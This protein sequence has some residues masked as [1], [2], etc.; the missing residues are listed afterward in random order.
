MG[1][2]AL[3]LTTLLLRLYSDQEIFLAWSYI[4]TYVTLFFSFALLGAE[5]LIIRY[6]EITH[7]GVIQI[8]KSTITF[9]ILGGITFLFVAIT[10]INGYLFDYTF[11]P[12]SLIPLL[13]ATMGILILYQ[14]N[15]LTGMLAIGQLVMNMWRIILC[16]VIGLAVFFNISVKIEL[17]LTVIMIINL[18]IGYS[19][20]PQINQLQIKKSYQSEGEIFVAFAISLLIMTILGIF[21]RLILDHSL[22]Y[23]GISFEDYFYLMTLVVFPFN[24]LGSYIGYVAAR[25]F[26]EKLT[27]YHFLTLTLQTIIGTF[28]AAIIWINLLEYFTTW[29]DLPSVSKFSWALI[30]ILIVIKTAYALL[31]AATAVKA[32]AK[33]LFLANGVTTMILILIGTFCY[34]YATSIEEV[35]MAFTLAWLSRYFLYIITLRNQWEA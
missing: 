26:R 24:L 19:I 34:Y 7:Q 3:F 6:A 35:I 1:A 25:H 21:D 10:V 9:L 23:S 13:L 29:L 32:K 2:C 14:I 22:N 16:L 31:S 30:A 17:I 4:A 12:L 33:A 18:L 5:Q 11:H 20:T 27:L 8:T 28:I 15:R